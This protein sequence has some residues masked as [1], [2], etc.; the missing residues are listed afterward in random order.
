[1]ASDKP[2]P[3]T[4]SAPDGKTAQARVL[5]DGD[6]RIRVDL[7][8]AVYEVSVEAESD[9]STVTVTTPKGELLARVESNPRRTTLSDNRGNTIQG[10]AGTVLGDR[11]SQLFDRVVLMLI[12]QENLARISQR[13]VPVQPGLRFGIPP[14]PDLCCDAGSVSNCFPPGEDGDC[15]DEQDLV[16]C[17]AG[18]CEIIG[19][20]NCC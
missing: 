18:N 6:G 1:M 2:Y 19:T 13:H 14:V 12:S 11:A 9:H 17:P 3:V 10:T 8:G 4:L 15:G 20:W 5:R 7:D 16:I